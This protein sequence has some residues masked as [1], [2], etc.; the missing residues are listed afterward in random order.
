MACRR[1]LDK[2][3]MNPRPRL[4]RLKEEGFIFIFSSE[5]RGERYL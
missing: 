4:L 2:K 1:V 5:S 3:V